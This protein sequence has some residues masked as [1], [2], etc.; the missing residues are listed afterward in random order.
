MTY[1]TYNRTQLTYC[2]PG[3][4]PANQ[5]WQSPQ[6]NLP[7]QTSPRKLFTAV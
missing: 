4:E 2:D 3:L 6:D 7:R 5:L 1:R